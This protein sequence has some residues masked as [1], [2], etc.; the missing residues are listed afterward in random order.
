MVSLR[1]FVQ[2]PLWTSTCGI[3]VRRPI[4]IFRCRIELFYTG[5]SVSE[6][7]LI[8]SARSH[9]RV[10]AL[11]KMFLFPSSYEPHKR[12]WEP[13]TNYSQTRINSPISHHYA[14]FANRFIIH[15]EE[16]Q[17]LR[18]M[19]YKY[20]ERQWTR[21]KIPR[22]RPELRNQIPPLSSFT[23]PS[24][25]CISSRSSALPDSSKSTNT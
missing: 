11:R 5:G 12:V 1:L 18:F 8:V 9:L 25:S 15:Y 21:G 22:R 3:Q 17:P 16:M 2:V 10:W 7:I 23:P 24:I 6:E 20:D 19:K 13:I 4:S 14:F